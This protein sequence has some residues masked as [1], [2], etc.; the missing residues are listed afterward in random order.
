MK[1]LLVYVFVFLLIVSSH[2][3]FRFGVHTLLFFILH[4]IIGIFV[5]GISLS[6]M[7]N[8]VLNLFRVTSTLSNI[9]KDRSKVHQL[10]LGL[11][12]KG[13]KLVNSI[14]DLQVVLERT[15]TA[16]IQ[17]HEEVLKKPIED[18]LSDVSQQMKG[19]EE[20]TEIAK[21]L[22]TEVKDEIKQMQDREIE[23][24][25]YLRTEAQVQMV[26]NFWT[27]IHG[28]V[29]VNLGFAF[30]YYSIWAVFQRF[31]DTAF[32]FP[33]DTSITLSDFLYYSV[34]TVSTIGYGEI[35]PSVWITQLLVILQIVIGGTFVVGI[36]G[37]LLS[38]LTSE[39]FYKRRIFQEASGKRPDVYTDDLEKWN[40]EMGTL[41]G[42]LS[43]EFSQKLQHLSQEFNR[44]WQKYRQTFRNIGLM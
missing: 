12:E 15:L 44:V 20:M 41:S 8:P 19:A 6:K 14:Q 7:L 35:N 37:V 22:E 5:I 24:S 38:L 2:L 21:K 34:V 31:G 32:R 18:A 33:A 4:G 27:E 11:I 16:L 29:F 26:K 43:Q 40:V 23:T 28:F 10:H 17:E 25:T 1:I 42:Q 39:E 9:T 30:V 13:T 3:F 36:I